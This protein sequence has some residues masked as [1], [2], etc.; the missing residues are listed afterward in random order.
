MD[1]E[2]AKLGNQTDFTLVDRLVRVGA[3]ETAWNRSAGPNGP[4]QGMD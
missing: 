4:T 3:A 1:Y 2:P